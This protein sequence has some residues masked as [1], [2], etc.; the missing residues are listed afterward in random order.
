MIPDAKATE[1][2]KASISPMLSVRQGA[3]AVEFYK[4]AFGASDIPH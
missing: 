1:N 4:N 2:L 3:R